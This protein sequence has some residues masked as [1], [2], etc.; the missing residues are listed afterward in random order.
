MLFPLLPCSSPVGRRSACAAH[1]A[2]LRRRPMRLPSEHT[3]PARRLLQLL[4]LRLQDAR[5]AAVVLAPRAPRAA[6]ASALGRSLHAAVAD[7]R[8]APSPSPS[9]RRS[10]RSPAQR[11]ARLPPRLAPRTAALLCISCA[12]AKACMHLHILV[13]V[14]LSNLSYA[15][16]V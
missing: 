14:S 10:F 7:A 1:S 13:E 16:E 6:S 5:P 12:T 15:L 3:C 4:S 8:L 2:H 11:S 9:R